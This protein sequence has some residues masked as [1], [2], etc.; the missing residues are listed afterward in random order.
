VF[1]PVRFALYHPGKAVS[2]Q[3]GR[4][5]ST[6]LAK[7]LL[8]TARPCE[9]GSKRSI[10]KLKN[11][12]RLFLSY[13]SE[14]RILWFVST[15]NRARPRD[16]AGLS[17]SR[18]AERLKTNRSMG[19]QSIRR[20]SCGSNFHRKN[21]YPCLIPLDSRLSDFKRVLCKQ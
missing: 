17:R 14:G 2:A 10:S 13:S 16:A 6:T 5:P 3:P 19:T 15:N 11:N 4:R 21:A 20:Y 1:S 18:F 9:A 8:R 12:S 7:P